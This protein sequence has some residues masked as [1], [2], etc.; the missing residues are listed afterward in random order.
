MYTRTTP[1]LI[2]LASLAFAL[3][4]TYIWQSPPA[5]YAGSAAI[6]QVAD[7]NGSTY[8][9][10]AVLTA[11]QIL[12]VYTKVTNNGAL[13]LTNVDL[14][15]NGT[16][17]GVSSIN[18]GFSVT[19]IA[20][21]T[22]R[23]FPIQIIATASVAQGTCTSIKATVAGETAAVNFFFYLGSLPATPTPT[24]TGVPTLTPTATAVPS[25]PTNCTNNAKTYTNY[26]PVQQD[27]PITQELCSVGSM[28]YYSLPM[29]RGKV[30]DLVISNAAS[31]AFNKNEAIQAAGTLDLVME[32][33][34]PNHVLVIT[35]DD[36][37]EHGSANSTNLDPYIKQYRAPMDGIY[38][39]RIYEATNANKGTY[40]F[41]LRNLSYTG[42]DDHRF[43][44][45]VPDTSGLCTDL[46]EPDGLPE[47][48]SLVFSNQVQK[49]HRLCPNGDADWVKFFAK[50][51]NTYVIATDTTSNLNSSS[52][53][54]TQGTDT[55]L[56]LFDRDGY[57]QLDQNDNKD[58]TSF[59]SQVVFTP[60]VDGFFYVQIKNIGDLGNPF[61]QYNLRNTVCPAG[62]T[63]C[64][65]RT[66]NEVP[67]STP[68]D[69]FFQ[70]TITPKDQ[71]FEDPTE[72]PDPNASTNYERASFRP[73]AE[74]IDGPLTTF[75]NRS[76]EY[77]W[78]RT[79]RPVIR[80]Q[81]KRS[82]LWGPTGLMAKA[83]AYLQIPG[84]MR[85]VQYFDKGRMEINNPNADTRSEWY[86][87][88]GLL[89]R[90]LISGRMQVGLS[91]FVDREPSDVAI[92]GDSGDRTGPTYA[93]FSSVSA[94]RAPN[95]VGLT[96]DQSI[97]RSGVVAPFDASGVPA[98][99][100][101][102]YATTTGHNIPQV[103][104]DYLT[105]TDVV[106]VNGRSTTGALMNNWVA[107]MGYPLSEAY[108][109]MS[110]INGTP[111]WV[112]VQPFERRVLTYVPNNPAGWQIEQ[113]NVGR[114]Y[115]RWRYG[116]DPS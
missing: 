83:E 64:A 44:G 31:T 22:S 32:L 82:W 112:L 17:T 41:T 11:G 29:T 111:Q 115:Y 15:I 98:A 25:I 74:L 61:F 72:T 92:T 95:R 104:Y 103:F 60:S 67:T 28:N 79:D 42:G 45:N 96:A 65:G 99:K 76:F 21:G 50:T 47:Q 26:Y 108:W 40:T 113:G 20:P 19:D 13:T 68:G 114:H 62:A 16:C 33:Y 30:Y 54:T 2:A 24:L 66:L 93:S 85:Q 43:E 75:V 6:V 84:G 116:V 5:A 48:S 8:Q 78:S 49:D 107:T 69:D 7:T 109:T 34:D 18:K 51:G 63:D 91:D 46:Y 87:T 1:R 77:L 86:V 38:V 105:S 90:E 36:S 10:D 55:I 39:V 14:N 70:P 53:T 106:Y 89:V 97:T 88:S 35:S 3:L 27:L 59:D 52:D 9:N 71:S 73:A 58:T 12:T 37:Y 81:V 110:T 56:T 101:G 100:L 102:F 23:V 94:N 4:S 57:T 80:G